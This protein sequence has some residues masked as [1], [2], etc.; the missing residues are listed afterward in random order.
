MARRY[1]SGFAIPLGKFSIFLS[2]GVDEK[3][4]R[5]LIK[6]FFS[7]CFL[8]FCS[9][10]YA[11]A[12]CIFLLP[13]SFHGGCKTAFKRD[14]AARDIVPINGAYAGMFVHRLA[15]I[16]KGWFVIRLACEIMR[17]R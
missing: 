3:S 12:A 16:S 1:R 9:D 17:P 15:V 11:V 8:E 10:Q 4:N 14:Q 6:S 2:R 13:F 5:R 7:F